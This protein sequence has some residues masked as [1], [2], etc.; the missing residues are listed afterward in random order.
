MITKILLTALVIL[1]AL[2]F[3]RH[4]SSLTRQQ[5]ALLQQQQARQR[6]SAMLIAMGLVFLTLLTSA[7]LYYWHWQQEHRIVRVR[8]INSLS[9]SEQSY[10]V[11]QGDIEG[12]RLRTP[13]GVAIYLSDAERL[14]V[15][16]AK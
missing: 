3:L 13:E 1:A 8:V 10:E 14:E 4:K 7:T 12:R 2:L 9:G 16:G 5:E 11:Y 6:R 15:E